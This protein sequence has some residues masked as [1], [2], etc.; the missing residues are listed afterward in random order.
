MNFRKMLTGEKIKNKR[1]IFIVAFLAM[2]PSFLYAFVIAFDTDWRQWLPTFNYFVGYETGFGGRKLIGTLFNWLFPGTITPAHIR[3]FI[4]TANI[5]MLALLTWL[6]CKALTQRGTPSLGIVVL[7]VLYAVGP[8]SLMAY[9]RTP[10]SMGFMETYQFVLL[11]IWL[12][13]YLHWSDGWAYYLVTLLVAACC[14]L[15]HHAFC[16][17]MMPAMVALCLMD[18]FSSDSN[19]RKKWLGYGTVAVVLAALFVMLWFFGGMNVDIDTLMASIRE[20]GPKVMPE[21]KQGFWTLFYANNEQNMQSNLHELPY[22]Y[23][24]FGLSLILLAP[25]L[26]IMFYPWTSAAHKAKTPRQRW[27]YRTVYITMIVLTLP[28]FVVATDY[29]R[30]WIGFFLGMTVVTLA[31]YA[32][33][34]PLITNRIKAMGLYLKH[35]WWIAAALIIYAAQ[36]CM[37][38]YRGLKQAVELRW[39]IWPMNN[40]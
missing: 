25:L 36:L 3:S 37:I 33:G 40:I 9:V 19:G 27:Q 1:F 31:T 2:L 14:I 17:T 35:H 38:D 20:R 21:D 6:V 4:L 13:F 24:E 8:F 28:I 5:L 26:Y 34:D 18:C 29:S 39:M 10:L 23:T 11:L 7:T 22:K 12:L 32:K 30:W 15:I 16:C